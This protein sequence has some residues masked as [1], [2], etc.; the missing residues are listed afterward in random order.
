[1]SVTGTPSRARPSATLA[2]LPP[3]WATN[4]RPPRWPT[5]S[6]SASPTTTNMYITTRTERS[7]AGTTQ[8]QR[9]GGEDRLAGH[10]SRTHAGCHTRAYP[11]RPCPVHTR[12]TEHVTPPVVFRIQRTG[13][14]FAAVPP[15]AGASINPRSRR[16]KPRR[17][18]TQSPSKA[19]QQMGR[20][21]AVDTV[22]TPRNPV[23]DQKRLAIEPPYPGPGVGEP[24]TRCA[25]LPWQSAR[26][27]ALAW[28][29]G[30]RA[31]RDS[32]NQ[33]WTQLHD[34]VATA[35]T[36]DPAKALVGY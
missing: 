2:G 35:D 21:A 34:T 8:A 7:G 6:T 1:M 14:C 15:T 3:G 9:T 18:E 25:R 5:R 26:W 36:D 19:A 4:V 29:A 10:V 33:S 22:S 30:S 16:D 20:F 32:W 27:P 11:S 17:P 24:A 13:A 28:A 12:S 23:V 31:D